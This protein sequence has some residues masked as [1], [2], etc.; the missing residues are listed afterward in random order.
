VSTRV[1]LH[2]FHPCEVFVLVIFVTLYILLMNFK[3]VWYNF[4][5]RNVCTLY[6]TIQLIFVVNIFSGVCFTIFVHNS[7]L[8]DLAEPCTELIDKVLHTKA[9]V[10]SV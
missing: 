4:Y 10:S 1:N 9:Y 7:K 6:A 5:V 3:S 2:T 8:A